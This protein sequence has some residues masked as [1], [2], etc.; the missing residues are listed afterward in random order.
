MKTRHLYHAVLF[1]LLSTS[2]GAAQEGRQ[3]LYVLS[4]NA[5]DMTVIDVAT[6]QI[7]GSVKVGPLPHGIAAPRS[8][9]D[10]VVKQYHMFGK[11]PNE[12]DVTADGRYVYVPALGDGVYEVFDTVKEKI[13]ARIPTDGLPHNVVASPDDK[14]M[15][16]SPRDKGQLSAEQMEQQGLPTSENEKIYVVATATHTVMTTIPTARCCRVSS[17]TSHRKNGR[18]PAARTASA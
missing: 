8:V 5:D 18:H 1:L 16:L 17:M 15:Y 4:S 2:V 9:N 13:V 3:K 6:N 11:R 7:I 12:I 14:Y 10:E